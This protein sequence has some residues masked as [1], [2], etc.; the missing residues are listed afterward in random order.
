MD[1]D[2][3][4]ILGDEYLTGLTER[5]VAE[6]RRARAEC[7]ELETKL[8]YLRRLVQGRHDIVAGERDRRRGG[9]DPDDVHGLVERLPEILADR[10]RAPGPGRLPSTID[11]G[12]LGGVLVDR[13]ESLAEAVPLDTPDAV[14]DD[15]LDQT[16]AQL[17]E[18]EGEI[19]HLRR[20][21]FDRIDAIQGELTHRYR[22][23]EAHVDD[24]LTGEASS[25]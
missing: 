25:D 1:Q 19:S 10:V 2:L 16:A 5:A 24:L 4:R 23:G 12:E 21:M 17:E 22:D 9:G 15:A 7:Q 14:S 11:P 8:S 18:L 3:E 6:L 13:F 20:E